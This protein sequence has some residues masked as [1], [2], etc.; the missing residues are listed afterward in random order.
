MGRE[1]P[2]PQPTRGL[3]S[4]VSSPS[5]SGAEP[6]RKTNLVHFKRHRTL[7]HFWLQDIVNH[8][9]SILQAEMQYSMKTE[10]QT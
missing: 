8:E 10:Q 6:Q 1:Y 2:P 4:I 7:E 3:G 5:G 9:N